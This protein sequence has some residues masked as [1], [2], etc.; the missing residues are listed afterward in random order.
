MA[1]KTLMLQLYKPSKH[2]RDLV[3]TALLHYAQALQFLLDRYCDEI[4]ELVESKTCVTQQRILKMIGKDTGKD[5]NA[6]GAQPFKD[7][8]K[9]EFAAI[10]ASYIA[11]KRQ[12]PRTGYPRTFLDDSRYRSEMAD[13][14]R[15]VDS[16]QIGRRNFERRCSK[17][18]RQAGKLRS[19]Y[20][21]R[22]AVNREYCLLYDEFK[23]RFYA[24]LYLMNRE[25][26][27]PSGDWTSG[28]SLKYVWAET[29]PMINKPGNKRYIIVPLAFGKRQYNDLKAALKDPGSLHSARLV[30][31]ENH[32]YLM[33][34]ME[35]GRNGAFAAVTTMGISRNALGGLNYTVCA[36]DGAVS[37]NGR[38]AELPDQNLIARLS[39][40]IVEIAGKNRSQAVLE[41]DGCKNDR[42]PVRQDSGESY[43]SGGQYALLVKSLNYKLPEKGLPPPIE[44][45]ANGLFLTCPGC[46][47]RTQRNRVSDELFACIRCGY[48]SEL[49]WVG[50]EALAKKL[51]RY[52]GDKVPITIR[53]TEDGFLCY[54]KILGFECELPQGAAD[55][56]PMY[57]KLDRLLKSMGGTFIHDTKKYAVWKKLSQAPNLQES[58]RLILK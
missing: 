8:I 12:N 35:C 42:M 45:S 34:N 49:E 20:F 40:K 19:L 50:S 17:L 56:I 41:A 11:R 2:K 16:E 51:G 5:L 6:F 48:A 44:V 39:N 7:S 54:N 29:P 14:I 24:K 55:Y 4:G 46:G 15:Q 23:D 27:I 36:E 28:L 53:K 58:I 38:I 33:V 13:C 10:A 37:E 3:D 47:A 26:S 57:E 22:Y 1:F 9:I 21:G 18:I 31:K 43:L 32:Y 52:R 30:K 25:E